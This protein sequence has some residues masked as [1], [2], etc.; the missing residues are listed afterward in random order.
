MINSSS[1]SGAQPNRASAARCRSR[2]VAAGPPGRPFPRRPGPLG[3]LDQGLMMAGEEL[4]TAEN[5]EPTPK[6]S[7]ALQWLP[8]FPS[9]VPR[10]S[11]LRLGFAVFFV[12]LETLAV[13]GALPDVFRTLAKR[14]HEIDDVV[15]LA[16]WRAAERRLVANASARQGSK[17]TGSRITDLPGD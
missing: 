14:V 2:S 10:C 7:D 11:A 1:M 5:A 17:L 12:A 9:T 13:G 16:S 8:I 6:N 3:E 4:P 15:R